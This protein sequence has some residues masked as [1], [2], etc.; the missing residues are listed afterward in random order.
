M[1]TVGFEPNWTAVPIT[2]TT[3]EPVISPGYVSKGFAIII[4]DGS[5]FK[6]SNRSDGSS[7]VTMPESLNYSREIIIPP[8]TI[9]CYL[10]GTTAT[11]ANVTF[12]R[13]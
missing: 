5:A 8:N 6:Q 7:P 4:E 3:W 10:Q 13:A 11:N 2:T 9:V 12:N 1:T